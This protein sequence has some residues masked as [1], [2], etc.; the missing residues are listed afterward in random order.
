MEKP[1][2]R[3]V[4]KFLENELQKSFQN[5]INS[6]IRLNKCH[7]ETADDIITYNEVAMLSLV[8]SALLRG[9]KSDNVWAIQEYA[10]FDKDNHPRGRAD[11]FFMFR[12]EEFMCDI[13]FEAKKMGHYNLKQKYDEFEWGDS[14]KKTLQQGEGYFDVEESYFS[15]PTFVVTMFFEPLS[16]SDYETYIQMKDVSIENTLTYYFPIEP[17]DSKIKLAV[18]GHIKQKK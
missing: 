9:K 17:K 1:T 18:Y 14:M 13:L 8:K 16:V 2:K 10:V 6:Y 4:K 15:E 11:A 7:H 3:T 12:E 5:E